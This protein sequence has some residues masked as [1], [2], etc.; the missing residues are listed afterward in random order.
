MCFYPA[1]FFN[2]KIHVTI[3]KNTACSL[4]L[5]LYK[6]INLILQSSPQLKYFV[7]LNIA[8]LSGRHISN[9]CVR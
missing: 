4:K 7:S 8:Y 1:S 5:T 3:V 2:N 6:V 9:I